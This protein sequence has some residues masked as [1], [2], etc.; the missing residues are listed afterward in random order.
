MSLKLPL[1]VWAASVYPHFRPSVCSVALW[2]GVFFAL[3]S[4]G[5]SFL[6]G[7]FSLLLFGQ[8][9][10]GEL[11]QIKHTVGGQRKRFKDSLKVSLKDF[12]ISTDSWESLASDRP[13]WHHHIIKG[14][15][16]VEERRPLQGRLEARAT[17]ANTAPTH[18]CP[19][20]GRGFLTRIGLI[21]HLRTLISQLDVMVIFDNEGRTTTTYCLGR[22]HQSPI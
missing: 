5:C 13:S 18:F 3:H 2:S 22:R 7:S 10:Y 14:A 19:T 1:F 20:C 4:F 17:S 15:H 6:C 9:F 12:N 11:C 8:L 21:S 16:A